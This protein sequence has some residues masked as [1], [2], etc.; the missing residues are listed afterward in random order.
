MELR[1]QTITACKIKISSSKIRMQQK[2]WSR[3]KPSRT[4]YF[5]I[6]KKFRDKQHMGWLNQGLLSTIEDLDLS[7]SLM[8]VLM[9]KPNLITGLLLSL[10]YLSGDFHLSPRSTSVHVYIFFLPK[11]KSCCT[12]HFVICLFQKIFLIK[13]FNIKYKKV[14][15]IYIFSNGYF[16]IVN[17]VLKKF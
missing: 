2:T 10:L 7:F 5:P 1:Y 12:Y 4:I 11:L 17:R 15:D 3:L 9:L 13:M 8:S 6:N 14:F 16:G